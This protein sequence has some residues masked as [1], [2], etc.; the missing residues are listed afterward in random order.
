MFFSINAKFEPC[1]VRRKLC[2]DLNGLH[3]LHDISTSGYYE[4]GKTSAV[5]R[6]FQNNE[7]SS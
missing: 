7:K 2:V 4:G 5:E 1:S 6:V 3:D